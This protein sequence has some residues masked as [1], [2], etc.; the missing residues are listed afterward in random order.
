MR[1]LRA[2]ALGAALLLFAALPAQALSVVLY[3]GLGGPLFSSYLEHLGD[4]LRRCGATV[5]VRGWSDPASG[6]FDVAIGQSA[7]TSTL[8]QTDARVKIAL[9]PTARF[10]PKKPVSVSYYTD[11]IG[12]ALPHSPNI[13]K[14]HA[15]HVAL[16][17]VVEGE[18]VRFVTGGRCGA[19]RVTK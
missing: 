19:G 4:A 13:Y 7:G 3:T 5:I 8:D 9:D 6:R 17:S 1:S 2:V 14:P 15:G 11:G 10:Y 18:V 12:I 16:P